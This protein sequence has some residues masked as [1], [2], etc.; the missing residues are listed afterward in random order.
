MRNIRLILVVFVIFAFFA[1]VTH[2]EDRV[3]YGG[4]LNPH[5]LY[6]EGFSSIVHGNWIESEDTL[7][8]YK[9]DPGLEYTHHTSSL[10]GQSFRCLDTFSLLGTAEHIFV[11]DIGHMSANDTFEFSVYYQTNR[12]GVY[13]NRSQLSWVSAKGAGQQNSASEVRVIST[14]PGDC[15]GDQMINEGDIAA[16][17]SELFD[18]DSSD[19]LGVRNGSFR[20]NPTGC[21]SKPDHV[22]NTDDLVCTALAVYGYN[23]SDLTNE[24]VVKLVRELNPSLLDYVEEQKNEK[25]LL[26]L[27]AITR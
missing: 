10:N 22:I 27:P 12:V 4:S 5:Y 14:K 26:Y 21:D 18:G 19:W 11:C 25:N 15:N 6:E 24:E 8:V 9:V 13:L 3:I 1:S 2:A 20:G 7:L 23:C 16:T 17:A